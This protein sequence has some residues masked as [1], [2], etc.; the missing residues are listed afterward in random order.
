MLVRGAKPM[1]AVAAVTDRFVTGRC[2]PA[3]TI[4]IDTPQRW[5]A[6]CS[7]AEHNNNVEP[8][9]K[10]TAM[11]TGALIGAGVGLVIA[12]AKVVGKKKGDS[13]NKP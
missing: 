12:I 2:P 8:F 6:P 3:A 13:S 7:M 1:T 4:R 11:L 5:H 9:E 10:E